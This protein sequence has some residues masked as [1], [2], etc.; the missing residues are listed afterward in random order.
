MKEEIKDSLVILKSAMSQ[1]FDANI[2]DELSYDGLVELSQE[3]D[4]ISLTKDGEDYA[5]RLVRSHR[6]AERLVYDVL[7]GEFESGACEFEH[8]VI[9]EI[10]DSICILLGHPRECPHGMPIPEGECCRYSARIARSSVVPLTELKIGQS[11]R[12]AYLNCKADQ[13]LH[14]MDSLHIRPGVVVQ[15]HQRYPTCVIECADTNIALDEQAASNICVWREFCQF[16]PAKKEVINQD[17]VGQER[18]DIN[19]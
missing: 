17:G 13:Q 6:L 18:R 16:Q 15:L 10:V 3:R 2:I 7:G 8:T 9:P 4:R 5:R 12:V 11:A 1:D 14:K 19:P